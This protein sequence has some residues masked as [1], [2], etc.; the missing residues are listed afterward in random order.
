MYW[1]EKGFLKIEKSFA[2]AEAY[3]RSVKQVLTPPF[4]A[5]A[6][7]PHQLPRGVQREGTRS[8]RQF[9]TGFLRSA[10]T[11][12]VVAAVA[13]SHQILPGGSPA[14]RTRHNVVQ[15]QCRT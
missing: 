1:S 11:L 9:E 3:E 15:G 2:P 5:V 10:V 8:P 6:D 7:Q 12:A 14:A 4:V 13:A